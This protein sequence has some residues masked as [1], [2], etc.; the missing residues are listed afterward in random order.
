M[1]QIAVIISLSLLVACGPE[2]TNAKKAELDSYRQ[3]VEEYNQKIAD[4][5]AELENQNDDSEA[6]ALLPVEI[7]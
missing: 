7:K 2:G 3:K 5:E 1:K 4:L 6:V